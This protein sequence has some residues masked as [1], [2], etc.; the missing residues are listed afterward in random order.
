MKKP[1]EQLKRIE[2]KVGSQRLERILL[3]TICCLALL[4]AFLILVPGLRASA[5]RQEAREAFAAAEE[6][7]IAEEERVAALPVARLSLTAGWEW[8][9][10]RINDEKGEEITGVP[11]TVTVEYP[12][13]DVFVF[14]RQ[15]GFSL[16][17]LPAGEYTVCLL[18]SESYQ[19]DG[20]LS[21]PVE[22]A[23]EDESAW[24]LLD[25]NGREQLHYRALLGPDGFLLSRSEHRESDVM[26]I[27]ADA[28]GAPEYGIR[29]VPAGTM[30]D[31]EGQETET[32]P[33]T[34]RVEL[35]DADG[36]PLEEYAF[37]TERL[38]ESSRVGPIWRQQEG[39]MVCY[40]SWGERLTG[41]Q[42]VD[43]KLYFFVP[44][45]F[46]AG[47]LGIDVSYYNESIDWEKVRDQGIAFAVAR[48]GG[49]GWL[50]GLPYDDIRIHEYLLNAREAGVKIGVYFYST[51][52][53][54]HEA[55]EEAMLALR[56]LD[57]IQL[58]LPIFIDM[59]HS[60]DYP[61]GRSDRLNPGERTAVIRAFCQTVEAA[62]YRAGVYTGQYFYQYTLHYPAIAQY[63][64]W[65][66][67]YTYGDRLPDFDERYDIW[68]FTDRGN[69][70]GIHGHTDMNVVF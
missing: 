14:E 26:P 40:N 42:R 15:S 52:I 57:G 67:N 30:L 10:V 12:G 6:A 44:E 53:N 22:G 59:E 27:D 60:G 32:Q 65:L 7:R 62:G 58:D 34:H 2:E 11:F 21:C 69:V 45:G 3:I 31:E 29:F 64:I 13:G 41:M 36:V 28:D 46:R 5:Q 16:S 48:I 50:S 49:R 17:G 51:A 38:T 20:P 19:G 35:Y 61:F 55:E 23:R 66:A 33:F 4:L 47:T 70:A 24:P 39:G 68:Q 37:R 18:L 43:G 63:T 25:E 1:A 54:A 8:L 56:E 9:N